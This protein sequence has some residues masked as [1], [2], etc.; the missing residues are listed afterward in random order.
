M[1]YSLMA[2][3]NTRRHQMNIKGVMLRQIAGKNANDTTSL[4][5]L[6]LDRI[7]T[8]LKSKKLE[9]WEIGIRELNKMLPYA[10]PKQGS[11]TPLLAINTKT[12][13][14]GNTQIF[15][16]LNQ[17]IDD[18]ETRKNEINEETA[19]F[20][21]IPINDKNKEQVQKAS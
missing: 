16:Q 9:Y 12:G 2:T 20:K 7:R 17:F 5:F 19:T 15:I 10:V 14:N 11:D 13:E 3:L 8:L 21:E 6:A 18:R 4:M 1:Y